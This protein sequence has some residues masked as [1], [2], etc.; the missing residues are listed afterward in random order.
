[1]IAPSPK[2]RALQTSRQEKR[3]IDQITGIEIALL[4]TTPVMN[5]QCVF[6]LSRWAQ[7]RHEEL[8]LRGSSL[9]FRLHK[10]KF[11]DLLKEG[12]HKDALVYSR[13]FA[14]FAPDHTKGSTKNN[15][16]LQYYCAYTCTCMIALSQQTIFIL[17]FCGCHQWF[18]VTHI[19]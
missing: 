17:L 3:F 18:S 13:N 19:T 10:L 11:L 8:K 1:M 9:E 5:V 6:L 4:V 15:L 2:Q 14:G 12:R 7:G 16:Y